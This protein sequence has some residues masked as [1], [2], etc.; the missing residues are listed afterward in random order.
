M[1][2]EGGSVPATMQVSRRAAQPCSPRESS[3]D[4]VRVEVDLTADGGAVREAVSAQLGVEVTEF[5]KAV[6][7]EQIVGP[8]HLPVRTSSSTTTRFVLRQGG[9]TAAQ[10]ESQLVELEFTRAR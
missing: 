1:L 7:T 4:C 10:T 8:D 3:G 5:D 6:H 9:S 2:V